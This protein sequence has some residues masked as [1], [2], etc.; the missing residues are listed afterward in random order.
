M[1]GSVK[2]RG[3][4]RWYVL[5]VITFIIWGTQ[6]P[7]LK[8]LSAEL[9]PFLL[10]LLRFSIAGLALLPFAVRN[11][12]IPQRRDL[13]KMSML[14]IVQIAAFGVLTVIGIRLSTSTNSSSLI[15]S[16]PLIVALLAP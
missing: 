12:I 3:R 2:P 7:P 14:G 4:T 9:P 5:L 1:V 8:I 13:L 15:N 11:K 10:N 6:H 16:N